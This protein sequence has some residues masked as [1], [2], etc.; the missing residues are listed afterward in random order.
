MKLD[1][2]L[3]RPDPMKRRWITETDPGWHRFGQSFDREI[4]QAQL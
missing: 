4:W 3:A 1:A 2:F